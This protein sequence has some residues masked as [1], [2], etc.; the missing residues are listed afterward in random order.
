MR[1]VAPEG[2]LVTDPPALVPGRGVYICPRPECL[3]AAVRRR[4]FARALRAPVTIPDQTLDWIGEWQRSA[5]T[6]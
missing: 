2:E 3:G 4:A 1:L 6:R 5:Y